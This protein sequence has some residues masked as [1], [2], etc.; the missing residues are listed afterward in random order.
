[1]S[2]TG[3]PLVE[4]DRADTAAALVT[5]GAAMGGFA[6]AAGPAALLRDAPVLLV[7]IPSETPAGSVL[8]GLRGWRDGIPVLLFSTALWTGIASLAGLFYRPIP[9]RRGAPDRPHGVAVDPN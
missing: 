1:M 5:F 6:A 2:A 4:Q 3:A 7:G 8:S 9:S